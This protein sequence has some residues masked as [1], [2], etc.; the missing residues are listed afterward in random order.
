[1]PHR[2]EPPAVDPGTPSATA[3]SGEQEPGGVVA[4]ASITTTYN[5]GSTVH[6][7]VDGGDDTAHPDLLDE[8][9]NRVLVLYREVCVEGEDG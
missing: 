5:D 6:L 1:M 4:L 9:V 2:V 3:L 7:E 8:L